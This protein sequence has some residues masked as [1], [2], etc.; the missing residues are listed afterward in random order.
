[1]KSSESPNLETKQRMYLLDFVDHEYDERHH[2]PGDRLPD[3]VGLLAA[4]REFVVSEDELGD[5]MMRT[6]K[7][8]VCG[9]KY[10]QECIVGCCQL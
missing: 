7:G 8:A 9:Q 3:V 6:E 2:F 1:M 5:E 10:F 4:S